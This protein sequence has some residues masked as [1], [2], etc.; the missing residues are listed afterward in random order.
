V[1]ARIFFALSACLFGELCASPGNERMH[2]DAGM[3]IVVV[4]Y[5]HLC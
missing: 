3:V 5:P 1:P 2:F 4:S